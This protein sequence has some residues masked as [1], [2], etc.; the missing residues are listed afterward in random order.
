MKKSVMKKWVKALRSGKYTQARN[1]LRADS[2]SYCCL[3]VLC[4]I[5]KVGQWEVAGF[6]HCEESREY[7]VL[8][9][10]VQKYAGIRHQNGTH[11]VSKKTLTSMNDLGK[12]FK[13]IAAYI[14]KNYKKL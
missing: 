5:S 12:S 10:A 4:D 3:G 9:E 8:P 1:S 14:E 7:G 2:V 13:Y 11:A 6:Y